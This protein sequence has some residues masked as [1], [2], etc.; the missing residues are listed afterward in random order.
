V[1]GQPSTLAH[2][3]VMARNREERE[4]TVVMGIL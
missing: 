3:A 4:E 1:A 2:G